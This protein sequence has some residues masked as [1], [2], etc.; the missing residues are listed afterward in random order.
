MKLILKRME[1]A[2]VISAGSIQ[3]GVVF[4]D[5]H[6]LPAP[7]ALHTE[8]GQMLPCQVSTSMNSDG[9]AP[10]KLTVTFIVDGDK[11]KVQGDE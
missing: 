11:V 4:N 1:R 8:D 5:G 10:V 9:G 7:F 6:E 3:D 2:R